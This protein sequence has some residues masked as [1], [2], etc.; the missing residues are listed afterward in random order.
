[1]DVVEIYGIELVLLLRKF[2][3]MNW[4]LRKIIINGEDLLCGL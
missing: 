1:M 3:W 2:L 4:V